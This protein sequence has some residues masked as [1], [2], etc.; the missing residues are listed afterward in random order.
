MNET[1]TDLNQLIQKKC[2][3]LHHLGQDEKNNGLCLP[4][5][6]RQMLDFKHTIT[7]YLLM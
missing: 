2:L 7:A 4:L 6:C 5:S 3:I 1:R